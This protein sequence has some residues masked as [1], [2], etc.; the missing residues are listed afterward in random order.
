MLEILLVED[1][2]HDVFFIETALNQNNIPHNLNTV[3]NGQECL[4]Y[5]SK[6]GKYANAIK[7]DLV[8]LDI[9]MP[10]LNGIQVLN[11]LRSTDAVKTIPVVILTSSQAKK[12]V[13]GAYSNFANNYVVKPTN[14]HKYMNV[15]GE[16]G[17]FWGNISEIP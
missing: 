4:D 14:A 16:I 2:Q 7:P 17:K 10:G 1:N 9:N 15:I 3:D 8:L 6:S 12:D 5:I 11:K 13:T